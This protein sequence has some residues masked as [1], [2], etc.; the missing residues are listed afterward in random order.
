MS[1][2]ASEL[3]AALRAGTVTSAELCEQALA[4][5]EGA[6]DLGIFITLD[7]AGARAAAA[8]ADAEIAA[9]QDRGP[10]HGI[11][12]ALKDNLC[13]EGLRTTCASRLLRDW[14]A[15]Y[16]A[17]VVQRLRDAGAVA[18]GKTNMDEFAMG[19]SNEN[20]AFGP[21]RNPRDPSRVP[22]GS[23][24]G[25]AA[26]VAAGIVPLALGS[27][28]GGSVRQPAALCGV[29]GLKPSWGRVSR[30]GLVAFGSSLDQVG[31]IANDVAGAAALLQAI[32]GPDPL[33][34]T[35]SG[36]PA[37]DYSAGLGGDAPLRV[38]LPR[39]YVDE[40]ST[41]AR[42]A[43]DAGLAALGDIEVVDVSLPHTSFAIA[44]YYVLA[45]AE[46]STN[47]S[48]F[49]GVRYG[50]RI[51]PGG[52]GLD[53]MYTATRSDGFGA[54]VQRRI[55]LGT[56]AL[57]SGYYDAYYGKAQTAREAI[58]G[59]FVAAFA[60]VDVLVGLT[61]PTTAFP[62]GSKTADPVQMYLSDI[63]T[64][65]ASL[66][67]LPAISVP[68]GTDGDGLPWGLHLIGPELAEARV[69]SAA[70]RVERGLA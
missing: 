50:A 41:E 19:S 47:L 62:L 48:R 52:E 60:D 6:S 15:P 49:D 53:G 63:F 67:G 30:Y 56:F 28:T 20:S 43:L 51:E 33:D 10:L 4:A 24:G 34:S 57:S 7:P 5:A 42:A 31:P 64:I 68:V 25:S 32:A 22:G 8:Q 3:A 26:A 16:D 59:D 69:L 38:G 61:A 70:A 17:T 11:P 18:I 45:S 9:G 12:I 65:P 27:D 54:E 21:V 29:V 23:S 37:G 39:E 2:T 46:A 44:T 55:L 35:C 66:A 36:E 14:I 1:A 13:T 40:L 58:R